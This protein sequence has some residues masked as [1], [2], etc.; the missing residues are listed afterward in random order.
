MQ[1]LPDSETPRCR[2]GIH[3]EHDGFARDNAS[4]EALNAGKQVYN[5][6]IK[7]MHSNFSFM[8]LFIFLKG[9]RTELC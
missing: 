1:A 8:F 5:Y 9:N 2:K 4:K 3:L 7:Q 6:V